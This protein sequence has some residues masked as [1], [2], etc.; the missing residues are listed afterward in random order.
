MAFDMWR[1]QVFY[2]DLNF[3]IKNS[4]YLFVF[5]LLYTMLTLE[6]TV[7]KQKLEAKKRMSIWNFVLMAI[8]QEKKCK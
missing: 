8:F 7:Y 3:C 5:L 2:K 4:Y 6:T 1:G